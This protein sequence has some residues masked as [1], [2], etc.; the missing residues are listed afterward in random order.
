MKKLESNDESA[1]R[2]HAIG[3]HKEPKTAVPRR[4]ASETRTRRLTM[5]NIHQVPSHLEPRHARLRYLGHQT[6]P[7]ML[8]RP[9][10]HV[11]TNHVR[12]VMSTGS[13]AV[14]NEIVAHRVFW[15]V[16]YVFLC[17][18][19]ASALRDVKLVTIQRG[20]CRHQFDHRVQDRQ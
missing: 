16:W 12:H 3:R 6:N 9:N 19:D 5:W 14:F 18:C 15:Y 4:G 2:H 20:K 7:V 17:E 11:T 13:R 8:Q 1:R 10:R